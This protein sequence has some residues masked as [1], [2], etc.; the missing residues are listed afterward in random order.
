MFQGRR[1]LQTVP[2]EAVRSLSVQKLLK[3]GA[4]DVHFC[5]RSCQREVWRE[6][7]AECGV[8]ESLDSERAKLLELRKGFDAPEKRQNCSDG[9]LRRV[10][11]AFESFVERWTRIKGLGRPHLGLGH[12]IVQ[13]AVLFAIPM[14]SL[15]LYRLSKSE[16]SALYGRLMKLVHLQL[17][18][19]RLVVPRFHI[20]HWT[21]LR[22]VHGLL[23]SGFEDDRLASALRQELL[24]CRDVAQVFDPAAAE[25]L[26]VGGG[27]DLYAQLALDPTALKDPK[28]FMTKH[29]FDTKKKVKKGCNAIRE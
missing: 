23:L 11:D 12:Y 8:G 2:S 29:T 28:L 14:G 5:S 6:H 18:Q 9:E 20:A 1:E 13:E 25:A 26:E 15:L 27:A 21:A 7:K 24:R 22:H 17:R 16:R 3:C 4:C 10:F 19:V